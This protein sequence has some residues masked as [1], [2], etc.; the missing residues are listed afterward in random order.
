VQKGCVLRVG[1]GVE[2]AEDSGNAAAGRPGKE[3]LHVP[4]CPGQAKF[5]ASKVKWHVI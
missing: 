3:Y 4:T 1:L 2:A 5:H